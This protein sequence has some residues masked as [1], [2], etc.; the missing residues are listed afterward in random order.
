[1]G[2]SHQFQ[3]AGEGARWESRTSVEVLWA[4]MAICHLSFVIVGY[5]LANASG[6]DWGG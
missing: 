3:R 6:F 1:M 5:P 4:L 2:I